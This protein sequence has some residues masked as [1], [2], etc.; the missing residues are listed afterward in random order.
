[1]SNVKIYGVIGSRAFRCLWCADELGVAYEHVPVKFDGPNRTP[2]FLAI[3]PNGRVPALKDGDLTL[4]ESMAIN[5]YLAQ[6]YGK[7]LW[8]KSVEAIGQVYQWS[9]WVMTEVE[10]PLLNVLLETLLKPEDKRDKALVEKEMKTL[11]GPFQVLEEGLQKS[12]YLLGS[13]FTLADLNVSAVML[14]ARSAKV[15]LSKYPKLD[16]WLTRCLDRPAAKALIAK[17]KAGG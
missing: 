4:Y 2:E 6:K 1:M 8:P 3:N 9:F 11:Q 10:K 7:A 12:N 15:D 13:E 16:Q 5:L 14:W 17:R